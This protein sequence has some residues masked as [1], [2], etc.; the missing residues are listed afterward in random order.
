MSNIGI[1]QEKTAKYTRIQNLIDFTSVLIFVCSLVIIALSVA[2]LLMKS[3]WY[4]LLGLIPLLFFR[5]ASVMQRARELEQKVELKGEIVGSLQL[6]KIPEDSKE[7]YSRE[8]IQAYIDDAATRIRDIRIEN[9][10]NY[11]PLIRSAGFV[12]IA[13]A[14]F[15]IQPAFFPGRFWYA[16][17]HRVEYRVS[18]GNM[19]YPKDAQADIALRVWG[20][21]MPKTV[22]IILSTAEET[23]RR[24]LKVED[25]VTRTSVTVSNPLVYSF[26]FFEH[27]TAPHELYP[28]EPLYIENL[29]FRL[30]YPG[31]TKLAGETR[32]GR[33]LVVP[34]QTAVYVQGR[35][36]QE[37]SQAR[38]EYGDTISF[39]HEGRDFSGRFNV[40][41]S[42]TATLH[43]AGRSTLREP[44]RIYAIP[45]L[46]PL[47]DIFYPGINVD[48]PYD[49]KLDIGI[50]CSDDYG[51]SAGTFY[52]SLD[53]EYT[54]ELPVNT[55][56]F[57]DT[58]V[59]TWDLSE[60]GMLPGDELSY[61][62]AVRDNSGKVTRS[63]IYYVHFP[64]MEQMYEEVSEKET[65]LQTDIADM[66]SE[67]ADQMK[68]AAR[69]QE[70]IM[71]E[72]DLSW[73]EQEQLGEMV[74]KEEEIMAKISEWQDELAKT[75]EK[76]K[77]GVI[78][79]QESI[80]RLKEI[81][82]I[83][84]E[85]APEELKKSLEDLRLA[86]ERKPADIARAL[87]QLKERQEELAR[88]LERS[89]EILKRFEQEEKLRQYAEKARDL[90]EQQEML[91]E[92]SEADGE[93]AAQKQQDIDQGMDELAEKLNE[94][95]SSEGLEQ[96]IKDALGQMA[97][98]MREMKGASGS[99]KKMGLENLAMSLQRLYEKLTQG[100]LVNLRKNL[101]ESL[102]QVIETSKAQEGI[103][104]DIDKGLKIDPGAQQEIIRATETIAESLF[105]QQAKSLLVGP[106]IGKGLAR[107]TLRMEEVL[108]A[109]SQDKVNRAKATDA[110]KE[111][112]LVAR[113]ILFALKMMMEDGS[114][115]GM[116]SFMQELANLTKSQ[117][118]LGQSMMSILPVPM[119]G[120]SQ[121]QKAQ[122]RRLAARQRDLREA[123]Q[124]LRGD[125]AAGKYQ[126]VLED[127]I[128]EMQD[129]EQELFQ[130]K[131]DREL[132]ER[133]RRVI[134]KLLDSQRSIRREDFAQKR[135]SKPGQ[136]VLDRTSPAALS[137]ELGKDE[138]RRLLQEEL[139]K[140]YP[141]EYEV[142]IREYFRVLLGEK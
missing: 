93:L 66:Q 103:I 98:Q 135:E 95:A 24:T 28:I 54:R 128:N 100:R 120:L 55:G 17:Y 127:V 94:L 126:D 22:Q 125:A 12:L 42:G 10:L 3:P 43:L 71:K 81:S 62:V 61:Y 6:A 21:Y 136:D 131:L 37:L 105:Q 63:T 111:L 5:P 15:L 107:A 118:M 36:S 78:L 113:D 48:L 117:M 97:A 142:Y 32:T 44:I 8:L 7:R 83:L 133:Q 102:N 138:L 106:Q 123:L 64:T 1:I 2:L 14:L 79:D 11:R 50:R 116:S 75:I 134:S 114:S 89:L 92:L 77:E 20:V 35:A 115:T 141:E 18:P 23:G 140:P 82:R 4:G 99:D 112:N 124:S 26:E 137:G 132:I 90:A 72:R 53:E 47:V 56:A 80:E 33:Q 27:R 86:M 25:G 87:D 38:F 40:T 101:L 60:L 65:M 59:F 58:V 49:M 74:E 108:K 13:L 73:S 129:I 67:H 41:E 57:E 76:L 52:Y 30:E 34:Y 139:R 29:T 9:F 119:Q 110:M 68:E 104:D 69:I 109:H 16:L 121:A 122:L 19:E 88:A 85:I 46:A 84:E 39:E 45:D 91:Q 96:E 51:L 70:K 130:Y 31:I